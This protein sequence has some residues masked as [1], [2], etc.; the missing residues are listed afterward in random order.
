MIQKIFFK[1]A[2]WASKDTEFDADFESVE[3]VAYISNF[4]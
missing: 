3:K 2:I 1:N 4:G